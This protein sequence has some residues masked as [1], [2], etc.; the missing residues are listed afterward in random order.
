MILY[1]QLQKFH[2]SKLVCYAKIHNLCLMQNLLKISSGNVYRAL[3]FQLTHLATFQQGS[4]PSA[5]VVNDTAQPTRLSALTSYPH[6]ITTLV[7]LPTSLPTPDSRLHSRLQ[8]LESRVTPWHGIKTEPSLQYTDY[9]SAL[10]AH[11]DQLNATSGRH[12]DR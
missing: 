2:L 8:T 7:R 4:R 10:E 3:Q 6:S 1:A 11:E 12:P 5:P 9:A